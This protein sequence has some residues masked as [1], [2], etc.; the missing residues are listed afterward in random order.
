MAGRVPPITIEEL[1]A[2]LEKAPPP[3]TDDVGIRTF[4][5]RH[6]KT[7]D[8]ILEWLAEVQADREA[9]RGIDVDADT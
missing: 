2:R 6:L 9:G 8:E 4:D 5:G 3:T 7:K 1:Q